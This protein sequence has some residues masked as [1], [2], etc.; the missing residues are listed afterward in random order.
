MRAKIALCAAAFAAA[1]AAG[2]AAAAE[3]D[4]IPNDAGFI[5]A[6][7]RQANGT[8]IVRVRADDDNNGTYERLATSFN[9][10]PGQPVGDG[11]RVASGDFD[12]D[13][14]EEL[15][16]SAG[17]PRPVLIYELNP[18]GTIGSLREVFHVFSARGVF[19][20]AGDLN[21]DGRAEL[22]T[23][24][25]TG[26]PAAVRI[27]SDTDLDLKVFDNM[28]DSFNAF[29]AT[30]AGGVRVAVGNVDNVGGAELVA[31]TG[32]QG[33]QV[34]IFTDSDFD[35]AVSDQPLADSFTMYTSSFKGGL[36]VA[37]GSIE[38]VGGNGAE[39]IVS[40]GASSGPPRAVVI[41]TD[42]DADGD[43]SD[44]AA[45][46]SFFAYGSTWR[47][48]I[49]V[50]AADTDHSGFFAEVLTAP[51]ASAGIK[52]VKIYDDQA[53][54]ADFL[55]SN[56]A[57]D[58]SFASMPKS[59]G[60]AGAYVTLVRV[61]AMSYA[62]RGFPSSI[63]D[64]GTLVSELPVPVSAGLIRDLDV[65]LNISHA[66]DS[67]LDVALVH[68]PSGIT[69]PLFTDVGSNDDGFIIRLNDEA[70]TDIGTVPDDAN[71]R[72]VTGTF[73]PEAAAVLSAFDGL[74]ASGVWQLVVTDD[75][76]ALSGVLMSWSLHVT[77]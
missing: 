6:G 32:P 72:A 69:V 7:S 17:A 49:R 73:N 63:P 76:A 12:G 62:F 38:G 18:D 28:T 8:G 26:K 77:Y 65:S 53:S 68:V 70:G 46:E 27:W 56:N 40:P 16:V 24:A 37:A 74:D 42:T 67:D 23:A 52:H 45:A 48:G 10:Y 33:R 66:F 35:R 43:V 64:P 25:A 47:S 3:L 58:H 4:E 59:V 51:G 15:V 19:V 39:V 57:L 2:P 5:V 60:S 9:P 31:A 36:F 50:A 22:V 30:F 75:A 71:D 14:N 29:G 61:T 34:K 11:V 54:D 1:I 44:N 20:A 41:R 55:I 13:G 21:G